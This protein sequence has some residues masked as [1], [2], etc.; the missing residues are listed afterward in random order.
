MLLALQQFSVQNSAAFELQQIDIDEDESLKALY[1][2]RV[3]VL[4]MG[5]EMLCEY[6]FDPVSVEAALNRAAEHNQAI[7]E[8]HT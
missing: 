5:D 6:F 3:P 2:T 1:D 7:N 8:E 4:M